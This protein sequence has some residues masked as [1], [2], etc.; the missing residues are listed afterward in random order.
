M[1]PLLEQKRMDFIIWYLDLM[2]SDYFVDFSDDDD[3]PSDAITEAPEPPP[4]KKGRR[5]RREHPPRKKGR[6]A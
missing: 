1:A 4:R 6:V 5:G 3:E 2:Y